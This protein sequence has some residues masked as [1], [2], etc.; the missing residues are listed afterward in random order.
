M[1]E[2]LS[3]RIDGTMSSE[4]GFNLIELLVTLGIIGILAGLVATATG[5][6]AGD[7]RLGVLGADAVSIEGS[8]EAFFAA[9]E[10]ERY[11]TIDQAQ[12]PEGIFISGVSAGVGVID[13]LDARLA[14]DPDQTFVPDFLKKVP[15]SAAAVSW[16]IDTN[17]GLVFFSKQG[18]KLLRPARSRLDVTAVTSSS[19][20]VVSAY[21]FTLRMTKNEA[22]VEVLIVEIPNG[23][24]IDGNPDSNDDVVIGTLSGSFGTDNPWQPGQVIPFTG[25][26]ETTGVANQ[27]ELKI[28]YP[29][30][31]NNGASDITREDAV[32]TVNVVIPGTDTPGEIEV[33]ISRSGE[34][35]GVDHNQATENWTLT[36]G[37]GTPV[38]I[39]NP[40]GTAVYRWLAE[41][42]STVDIDDV[43]DQVAG[44]Q[45]VVI[46]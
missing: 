43:F 17:L 28:D 1:F 44:N 27:W 9:G 18:A 16:R 25:T 32:H 29:N 13:F 5:S 39:T 30:S 21:Q 8:A 24:G 23:Y 40:S 34:P 31:V 35:T 22:A 12:L 10:P 26:L 11:P 15:D 45:A 37:N 36:I 42:H 7:A 46:Q 14:Q 4:R 20:G 2:I 33:V 19:P 6:R 41:E 3:N 38:V